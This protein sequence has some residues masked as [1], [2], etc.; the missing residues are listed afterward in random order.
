MPDFIH[1]VR[2]W[3]YPGIFLVVILGNIG[4]PVP[5]ET[6][7]ALAGYLVWAGQLRVLPV[8]I[9][10]ILSA[11]AGD[12]LGYWLGRNYGRTVVDRF[13][14]NRGRVAAA[15]R[16]IGRYGVLA[17]AA[18]RFVGGV[19]FLAGPLAGAMGLPFRSFLFGNFL[20]AVLFVPYAVGMGYAIG[21]GLG[22]YVARVQHALGTVGMA[23][24]I[25]ALVLG[26]WRMALRMSLRHE[27]AD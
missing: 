26:A 20:G 10:A 8:L 21:Y 13:A 12:T 4:L 9:V 5:E 22:P 25:G 3:G 24:V 18:A 6:V 17:V 19:R 16:F 7:L 27:A 14:Q 15:E 1:L 11:V 2:D 23:A